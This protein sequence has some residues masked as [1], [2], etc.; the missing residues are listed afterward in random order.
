MS[1]RNVTATLAST[2]LRFVVLAVIVV[3]VFRMATVAYNFGYRVFAE[4]PVSEGTGLD[5]SVAI[6]DDM[7]LMDIAK[8][9]ENQGLIND[10]KLFYVQEKVS[11]YKDMVKPGMYTL[12]TSMTAEEMLAIMGA[13]SEEATESAI[14]GNSDSASDMMAE[15][16]TT[17]TTEEFYTEDS[18]EAVIDE[19]AE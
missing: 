8:L 14:D 15:D 1:G 19:V 7:S 11:E 6:T 16:S 18:T 12:N 10:A 4:P 5:I 3:F 9:L 2:I 17:D 13:D